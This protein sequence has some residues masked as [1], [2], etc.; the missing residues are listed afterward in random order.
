MA[1]DDHDHEKVIRALEGIRNGFNN[2]AE[3]HRAVAYALMRAV[4][5]T[6]CIGTEVELGSRADRIDFTVDTPQG[7]VG[8]ECKV[9][10]GDTKI[11]RQLMRYALR[12]P[13][14]VLVTTVPLELVGKVGTLPGADAMTPLHVV[15]VWQNI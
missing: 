1:K 9:K 4:P 2:E 8:I 5:T 11:L 15:N 13:R 14:L 12:V 3:L 6:W 10:G 7:L